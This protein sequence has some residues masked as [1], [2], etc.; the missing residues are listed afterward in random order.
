MYIKVT[1]HIRP[2]IKGKLYIIFISNTILLLNTIRAQHEFEKKIL[3]VLA[4][5][6]G[7]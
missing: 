4:Y 1:L 5:K 7:K 6:K 2:S 3:L